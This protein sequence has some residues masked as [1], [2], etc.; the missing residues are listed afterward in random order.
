WAELA[1]TLRSV[2]APSADHAGQVRSPRAR[3]TNTSP[4][5]TRIAKSI[6]TGTAHHIH[7]GKP[8]HSARAYSETKLIANATS[9]ANIT[10]PMTTRINTP[11]SGFIRLGW[12]EADAF[13]SVLRSSVTN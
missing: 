12:V 13:E 1:M 6:N 9:P 7:G 4:A 2:N 3:C 11:E 5:Y 8:N 10:P